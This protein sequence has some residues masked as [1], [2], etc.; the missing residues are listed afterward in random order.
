MS[1][2]LLAAKRAEE[3]LMPNLRRFV[4]QPAISPKSASKSWI[5]GGLLDYTAAPGP[6]AV[7]AR[8]R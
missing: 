8:G 6:I 4:S 3:R 7:L 1:R 2:A 5:S